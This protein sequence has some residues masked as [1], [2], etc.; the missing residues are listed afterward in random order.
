M[1]IDSGPFFRV[2]TESSSITP[3]IL[4]EDRI[5]KELNKSTWQNRGEAGARINLK[6]GLQFEVGYSRNGYLDIIMMPDLLQLGGPLVT[7]ENP[8]TFTQDIIVDAFHA[9][10]GFQF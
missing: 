5:Q 4:V 3:A 6:N 7:N 8:Q 1:K 9:G 2:S 10:V